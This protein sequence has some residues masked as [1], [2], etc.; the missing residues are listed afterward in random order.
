[1]LVALRTL[2]VLRVVCPRWSATQA[3]LAACL[4]RASPLRRLHLILGQSPLLAKG[5]VR[6]VGADDTRLSYLQD[7]QGTGEPVP[8]PGCV[9]GASPRRAPCQAAVDRLPS[10][11]PF[12]VA[13]GGGGASHREL[14]N[15]GVGQ[16]RQKRMPVV[17]LTTLLLL[18]V[19]AAVRAV[20]R[21]YTSVPGEVFSTGPGGHLDSRLPWA[22][23][24]GRGA[25][26]G[27]ARGR[28]EPGPRRT[29]RILGLAGPRLPPRRL[30]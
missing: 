5:A 23:R 9:R 2:H 14:K 24:A 13:N 29:A 1:M 28:A 4:T 3:V 12:N 26:A 10:N 8:C 18:G 19:V 15:P 25:P 17:A 21:T 16:K 30:G 6:D 27:C 11:L 20:P 7:V 22:P